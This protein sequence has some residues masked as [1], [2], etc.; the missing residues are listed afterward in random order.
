M[1]TSTC[2][3]SASVN[4]GQGASPAG[5]V[6][7]PVPNGAAFGYSARSSSGSTLRNEYAASLPQFTIDPV[8]KR[9]STPCRRSTLR[10]VTPT[11]A[12]Y[13]LNDAAP[14][15]STTPPSPYTV[16]FTSRARTLLRPTSAP[17]SSGQYTS[18]C[19]ERSPGGSSVP[20]SFRVNPG[21][22][23]TARSYMPGAGRFGKTTG[24]SYEV[25]VP[26][27]CA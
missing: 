2:H 5:S 3:G 20:S 18:V 16:R 13:V 25:S 27:G 11:L 22:G 26:G 4:P 7:P 19:A 24:R 6:E 12:R 23:S 17:S 21:W 10:T 8:H 1:V 9:C 14:Q 15:L